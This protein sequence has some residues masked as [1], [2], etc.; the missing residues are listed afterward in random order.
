LIKKLILLLLLSLPALGQLSSTG[1][2][3]TNGATCAVT[4]ACINLTLSNTTPIF[5]S[6]ASI[7]LSGTFTGTFQFEASGDNGT[8]YVALACTPI[9]GGATQTATTVAGTWTCSI[10]ALTNMR[11]RA[12]AAVTGAAVTTI[13][14]SAP[15]GG[16]GGGG[17]GGSGGAVP[18]LTFPAA[19]T[20]LNCYGDSIIA[21][22]NGT[23]NANLPSPPTQNWCATFAN[24][25]GRPLSNN[26]G[27]VNSVL[28]LT[29]FLPSAD[30][31]LPSTAVGS[32]IGGLSNHLSSVPT[33]TANIVSGLEQMAVFLAL[34]NSA[35]VFGVAMTQS[36]VWSTV[37]L[38]N[39][40]NEFSTA[41]NA[42]L[43]GT[44]NGTTVYYAYWTSSAG[45]YGT[46]NVQVDGGTAIPVNFTSAYVPTGGGTFQP[47]LLRISGLAS[48][49]HTVVITQT[50]NGNVVPVMWIAGNQGTPQTPF[51]AIASNIDRTGQTANMVTLNAA[52]SSMVNDLRA[53]G[54]N[55]VYNDVSGSVSIAATQPPQ[56]Y[57]DLI[58]PTLLG[59]TLIA[60]AFLTNFYAGS[61][62]N[63]NALS[64][65]LS[66][67]GITAAG[68][69][70]MYEQF[71]TLTTGGGTLLS[72]GTEALPTQSFIG[73][74]GT[75]IFGSAAP[76]YGMSVNSVAQE[77][78]VTNNIR[79]P[80]TGVTGFSSGGAAATAT[81]TG[82]SRCAAGVW[83]FGVNATSGNSGASLKAAAYMS[84]G[85]KFTSNAGCT[86]SATAGGATAGKFTVGQG[87]ACTI[88]ITMGNTATAPN[89]WT[90]TAYDQTAV[91]AVAIR[92]TASSA[93]SCSLL[94][95]VATNDVITFSAVGY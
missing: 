50:S 76:A 86:E 74:Q 67:D 75:G 49:N 60:G 85:T 72:F 89:G 20:S 26:F 69:V 84:V 64:A 93:T 63:G 44:V 28:P 47:A 61:T 53:D 65:V 70:A 10:A 68:L 71:I 6:T 4:N 77:V 57:S 7:T 48:G 66:A 24:S 94:M 14:A 34:P 73:Q 27:V 31:Q 13:V 39:L 41:V 90:C 21:G 81:D 52:M 5:T 62:A 9:A 46:A 33:F 12:S 11:V 92:Q 58:H 2:I 56:Y 59:A 78:L 32:I 79:W 37:P 87:T 43:T 55:V 38:F 25:I 95:T 16:S 23:A 82:M 42:T 83:C 40:T 1:S 88:I 36:G 80:S 17:G 8:T 30:L 3:T 54:L 45:G 51:V 35:K 15:S 22:T 18:T 91:P 19:V 29:G